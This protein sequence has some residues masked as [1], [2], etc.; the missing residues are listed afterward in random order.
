[1]RLA[2][3]SSPQVFDELAMQLGLNGGDWL[4]KIDRD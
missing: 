1:V 3:C 2:W 4:L